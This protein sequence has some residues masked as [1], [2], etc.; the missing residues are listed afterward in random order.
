MLSTKKA[1]SEER[2][3]AKKLV[4]RRT[5]KKAL[6]P[7]A[8]VAG[9]ISKSFR[10]RPLRLEPSALLAVRK[11]GIRFISTVSF[12]CKKLLPGRWQASPLPSLVGNPHHARVGAMLAIALVK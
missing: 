9:T 6:A 10:I 11:A 7:K 12:H 8:S 2:Y 5:M 3:F 4:L 1:G